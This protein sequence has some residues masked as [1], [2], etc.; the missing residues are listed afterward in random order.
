MGGNKYLDS[1]RLNQNPVLS[2]LAM[3]YSNNEFIASKIYP[4]IQVS[5]FPTL[6]VPEM[7]RDHL[8]IVSDLRTLYG[9][10]AEAQNGGL[11]YTDVDLQEHTQ[12]KP[13]DIQ[14]LLNASI[15][16]LR[17]TR[18]YSLTEA[19]LLNIEKA[20]ADEVQLAS[21]YPSANKETLTGTSQWTHADSDPSTQ[22][23]NAKETIREKVGKYPNVM[24]MGATTKWAL[25]KNANLVKAVKGP[26]AGGL[27]TMKQL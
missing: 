22:I 21:N 4:V 19:M 6:R 27:V 18:T 3:G 5:A 12:K 16:D 10:T 26:N 20:V 14:E 2:S 7:N 25:L 23:W 9:T 13:I 17:K 15:I 11:T 1:L 8:K 24:V